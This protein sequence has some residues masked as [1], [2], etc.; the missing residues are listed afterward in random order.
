MARHLDRDRFFCGNSLNKVVRGHHPSTAECHDAVRDLPHRCL[1]AH[2]VEVSSTSMRRY[3]QPLPLPDL[4]GLEAE[5]VCARIHL[6]LNWLD[7]YDD[8]PGAQN[9]EIAVEVCYQNLRIGYLRR[10]ADIY[11]CEWL[12][13]TRSLDPYWLALHLIHPDYLY[14]IVDEITTERAKMPDYL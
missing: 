11:Y 4:Q 9:G 1:V 2:K 5:W 3:F 8:A 6:S 10:D 12:V 14:P 7:V 13:G